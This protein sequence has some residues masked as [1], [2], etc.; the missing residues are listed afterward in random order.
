MVET[1]FCSVPPWNACLGP[2]KGFLSWHG[3]PPGP[4]A[5][6]A[7]CFRNNRETKN[8]APFC[9]FSFPRTSSCPTQIYLTWEDLPGVRR[10]ST[11]L[12]GDPVWA[13]WRVWRRSRPPGSDPHRPDQTRGS[14]SPGPSSRLW[15]RG[16][17]FSISGE[18]KRLCQPCPAVKGE[19]EWVSGACSSGLLSKDISTLWP[20]QSSFTGLMGK[21]S[22]SALRSVIT[23]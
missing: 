20:I 17:R 21:G 5:R 11:W 9:V 1:P 10:R 15:S 13:W 12:T 18:C 19:E 23:S 16:P 7:R 14:H 22:P 6:L 8:R 4:S 2:L 3:V